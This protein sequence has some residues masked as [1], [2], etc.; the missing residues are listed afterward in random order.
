MNASE[1]YAKNEQSEG[2]QKDLGH[3]SNRLPSIAAARLHAA[4]N[5]RLKRDVP[6]FDEAAGRDFALHGDIAMNGYARVRHGHVGAI[7]LNFDFAVLR[8][9]VRVADINLPVAI[10]RQV[11]DAVIC[12]GAVRRVRFGEDRAALDV[13]SIT[14]AARIDDADLLADFRV[15]VPFFDVTGLRSLPRQR[16]GDV[17]LA[18]R[19]A[20][21]ACDD[22]VNGANA[23]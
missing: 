13:S 5:V 4:M 21:A 9:D 18:E 11:E 8:L 14:R 1:N 2:E 3:T 10:V 16:R 7:D 12:C 20:S 15:P 23:N 6:A 17:I 19:H 22:A